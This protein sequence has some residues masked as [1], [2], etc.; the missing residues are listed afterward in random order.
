MKISDDIFGLILSNSMPNGFPDIAQSFENRLFLDEGHLVSS[1]DGTR[2]LGA[3]EVSHRR[4]TIKPEVMKVLSKPRG[5]WT[6]GETR[7]Y[8]WC[9]IKGHTIREC[10]KKKEHEEAKSAGSSQ[11][12]SGAKTVK[13]AE[14]VAD[15]TDVVFEAWDEPAEVTVSPI[16]MSTDSSIGV[17]DTGAT[18][19]VFNDRSRFITFRETAPIPVKMADGT[20]GGVITGVG[21][22]DVKS[23][24]GGGDWLLLKT[25]YLCKSL[26]HSLISGIA[27]YE[28]GLKITT[29]DGK[30]TQ[31]SRQGRKW[32]LRVCGTAV[33]AMISESYNLWHQRF[34]HPNERVLR[35][36]VSDQSCLGLPEKLGA[37]VPCE[38]CADAKSTK[39]STLG[40]TLRTCEQPLQLVVADLCGPFQEKGLG[41]ASYFLQ[42]RDVYSTFV[43]VYPIMH[44]Y[45]VTGIV[46]R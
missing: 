19:R 25:V 15:E 31:A 17:F 14:V 40:F 7:T 42:I 29:P 10:K 4:A 38:T 5:A 32:I 28:D 8:F 2:A 43:K 35:Q 24:D 46:K 37:T 45:E 6:G 36:M 44:K 12:R 1:S 9:D 13:L 3:A 26:R 30:S 16:T 20:R 34:G 18:H 21:S 33:S 27:I 39:T 22:V 41:G 23:M 11:S